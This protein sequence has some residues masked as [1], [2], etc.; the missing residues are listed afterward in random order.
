MLN[1][2]S[3]W[4]GVEKFLHSVGKQFQPPNLSKRN[5]T[6]QKQKR[7]RIIGFLMSNWRRDQKVTFER[8]G[9]TV[10][11]SLWASNINEFTTLMTAFP[12]IPKCLRLAFLEPVVLLINL[13]YKKHGIIVTF[14]SFM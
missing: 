2:S 6:K 11:Q 5:K 1:F 14:S 4:T 8:N 10:L 3:C 13:I 7:E 12:A 9:L